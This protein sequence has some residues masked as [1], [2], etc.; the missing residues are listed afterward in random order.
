MTIPLSH[1]SPNGQT[2]NYN[3]LNFAFF[4]LQRNF[5]EVHIK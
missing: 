4:G 3:L 2:L 1:A 5:G